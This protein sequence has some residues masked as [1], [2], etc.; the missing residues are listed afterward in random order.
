MNKN[1]QYLQEI[2]DRKIGLNLQ[3]CDVSLSP[4]QSRTYPS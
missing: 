3:V 4:K 1:D 2:N